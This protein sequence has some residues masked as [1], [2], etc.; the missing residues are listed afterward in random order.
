MLLLLTCVACADSADSLVHS[1]A[2]DC[3]AVEA[4]QPQRPSPLEGKLVDC[5]HAVS[6]PE[7]I[8][9]FLTTASRSPVTVQT[10][11]SAIEGAIAPRPGSPESFI[12]PETFTKSPTATNTT[13]SAT[14]SN[15][16][17]TTSDDWTNLLRFGSQGE[18]VSRLQ[19]RL[20]QL[21]Y[22]T[23][24]IDGI[25][26]QQTF[27]AVSRFQQ[28]EGLTVDGIVGQSTWTRLQTLLETSAPVSMSTREATAI[29]RPSNS[30]QLT[31]TTTAAQT[32]NQSPQPL[33]SE[34]EREEPANT[35]GEIAENALLPA[36]NQTSQ[37]PDQ[38]QNTDLEPPLSNQESQQTREFVFD[39]SPSGAPFYFW[40]G[41]WAIVYIGGMLFIFKDGINSKLGLKWGK[42]DEKDQSD[43]TLPLF[44]T[45]NAMGQF[46]ALDYSPP[47]DSDGFGPAASNPSGQEKQS[48]VRQGSPLHFS[49]ELD[50]AVEAEDSPVDAKPFED[51]GQPAIS[52][53]LEKLAYEGPRLSNQELTPA[54]A[55]GGVVEPIKGLFSDLPHPLG[56]QP[57]E[58]RKNRAIASPA[59]STVS[60]QSIKQ[61]LN[62]AEPPSTLIA[63]LPA[64]DPETQNSYTYVLLDNAKGYFLLKGN[65]LRV[66]DEALAHIQSDVDHSIT[67]RRTD[68]QGTQVDKSFVVNFTKADD[69]AA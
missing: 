4:S 11:A 64:E 61:S 56:N 45:S 27:A 32:L 41:A 3:S 21:E 24:A 58:R 53:L 16:S 23:G 34:A 12:L 33:E 50:R 57:S 36:E 43:I 46:S 54:W 9:A 65:E 17:S 47:E 20:Q 10:S 67:L 15:Q 19:A 5:T 7:A 68:A 30:P 60:F 22:Y 14:S 63:T 40:I 48:S 18:A 8:P 39:T 66:Y 29:L 38:P 49:S 2:S 13:Q 25:Y 1:V 44:G 35:A 37:T 51:S 52:S 31:S 28:A 59:H 55:D 6:A 42:S 69:E 26:G 62:Q